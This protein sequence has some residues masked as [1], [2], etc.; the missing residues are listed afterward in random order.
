M[1]RMLKGCERKMVMVPGRGTGAFEV[2]YFIMRREHERG[3]MREA[4]LLEEANRII[5]ESHMPRVKERRGGQLG[6]R[7]LFLWLVGFLSG[8]GCSLLILSLVR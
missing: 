3:P 5:R 7:G 4:D 8:A 2:A 1:S 6:K